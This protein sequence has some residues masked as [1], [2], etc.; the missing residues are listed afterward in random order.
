SYLTADSFQDMQVQTK[1]E[2]GGLGLEVTM[3]NGWVK[4]VS[5][6]DDTPAARAG[7]QPGDFIIQLDGATVQGLT[8]SEAVDKMRGPVNSTIVLTVQRGTEEPFDVSITRDIIRIRSV[9]SELFD[10]V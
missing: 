9:R 1:G 8:L 2:F 3:E 5:P 6:I 7:L 10:D 4:V